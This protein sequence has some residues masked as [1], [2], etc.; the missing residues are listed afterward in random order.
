VSQLITESGTCRMYGR[1]G[2]LPPQPQH[3]QTYRYIRNNVIRRRRRNGL[4][5]D[6]MTMARRGELGEYEVET[7]GCPSVCLFTHQQLCGA[8]A[9][10]TC[11][12]TV[13]SVNSC[14]GTNRGNT[15]LRI[16]ATYRPNYT[17]SHTKHS[18]HNLH[19]NDNHSNRSLRRLALILH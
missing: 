13:C 1:R 5:V 12:C 4:Y 9:T 16:I 2:A 11:I 6:K 14:H 7:L 15:F 10:K 17:V 3:T 18:K 8:L 19:C